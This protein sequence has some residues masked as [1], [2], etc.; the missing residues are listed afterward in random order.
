LLDAN[1]AANVKHRH[2]E[3]F[4]ELA[5]QAGPALRGA[6]RTLWMDRLELEHDNL[7]AALVW[8]E[9]AHDADLSL[10]LAG[11]LAAFWAIAGYL[12]EGLRWFDAVLSTHGGSVGARAR[13][14]GG[15]GWL[16]LLQ[17]DLTRARD[18]LNSSL[19]L[20]RQAHDTSG[21]VDILNNLGRATLE[22]GDVESAR[23]YF[24]ESVALS[25]SIGQRWGTA[26]ALTGLGQVGVMEADYDRARGLF[27]QALTLYRNLD[28]RRHVAVTMSNFSVV[29]LQLHQAKTACDACAEALDLVAHEDDLTVVIHI[30]ESIA[31]LAEARARP[32]RAKGLRETAAALRSGSQY[33]VPASDHAW[34]AV[35][36]VLSVADDAKIG[37]DNPSNWTYDQ[38]LIEALAEV[39]A[40]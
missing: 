1:F 40:D 19:V 27:S 17:G 8:S 2:A 4:L 25:R 30:L 13:A 38:A 37:G 36:P 10:R 28:S 18:D 7:R 39:R 35:A 26:F 23:G 31:I 33:H 11:Y 32:A 20:A 22:E 15:A 16:A 29:L 9:S 21:M 5:E 14:H 6:D 3:H 34:P 24:D 12:R